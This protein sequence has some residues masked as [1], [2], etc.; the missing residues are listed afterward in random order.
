[1]AD[2]T[3][4]VADL[5][6]DHHGWLKTWLRRKLGCSETAADV[7]QDTFLRLLVSPASRGLQSIGETRAYLRTAANH[8]CIDLWR[9]QEIEQAWLDS[10]ASRPEVM[11][12][13][14]EHQAI[15]VETL[16]EIGDMLG[17]LSQKAATAFIMAQVDGL[18]Y[19]E[20]AKRLDVSERMVKKYMAQA[21]LQC[22]LIEAD[23]KDCA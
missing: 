10:L 15:V 7:A 23:L 6:I 5:Y 19:R 12:P 22:A 16:M 2:S 9:R 8:L 17:R 21:M 3:D 14:P 18:P 4:T 1:M 20:I 11:T 13:S